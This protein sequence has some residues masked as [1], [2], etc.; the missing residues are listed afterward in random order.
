MNRL[1]YDSFT[2]TALPL[3]LNTLPVH[4]RTP[5]VSPHQSDVA[6]FWPQTIIANQRLSIS[7]CFSF[8]HS[9]VCVCVYDHSVSAPFLI[10]VCVCVCGDLQEKA[11]LG[12]LNFSLCYLP[13][14]GRLTATIIKAT[15]LKAMD[16]TGFSGKGLTHTHT[17]HAAANPPASKLTGNSLKVKKIWQKTASA[18]GDA[19]CFLD[20]LQVYLLFWV[21]TGQTCGNI[22]DTTAD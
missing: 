22:T 4:I 11:D 20:F 16:L 21:I 18:T 15:N 5:A 9:C 3:R 12:E 1:A 19:C 7:Y 17:H 14:A 6:L 10:P 2:V 13:T 8:S